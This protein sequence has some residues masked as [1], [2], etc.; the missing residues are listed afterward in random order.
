MHSVPAYPLPL[1]PLLPSPPL[2]EVRERLRMASED[3]PVYFDL[4]SFACHKAEECLQL[5]IDTA[6]Q[7]WT[8]ETTLS[9]T[10]SYR[11]RRIGKPQ[12][13]SACIAASA[14][15]SSTLSFA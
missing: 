7:K 10:T 13:R 9:T 3:T 4:S 1:R 8:W 15:S 2:P 11:I 5:H 14:L 6:L 12:P